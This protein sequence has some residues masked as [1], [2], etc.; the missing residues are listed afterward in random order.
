[1]CQVYA[2]V[3]H[4]CLFLYLLLIECETPKFPRCLKNVTVR[5]TLFYVLSIVHC[6]ATYGALCLRCLS[7][8]WQVTL[9]VDK[10]DSVTV[11]KVPHYLRR[12]T[13]KRSGLVDYRL[14][15][16]RRQWRRRCIVE[17]F[18]QQYLTANQRGDLEGCWCS[19]LSVRRNAPG[20]PRADRW[21]ALSTC[22]R[23][24]RAFDG[25]HHAS[26]AVQNIRIRGYGGRREIRRAAAGDFRPTVGRP[27]RPQL[28]ISFVRETAWRRRL[29][30]IAGTM[31]GYSP[32]DPALC[33]STTHGAALICSSAVP[34]VG[35]GSV[36]SPWDH[37]H[38]RRT[39][40][41]LHR[42]FPARESLLAG[43]CNIRYGERTGT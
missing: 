34:P 25:R 15:N 20:Q 40:S 6:R 22:E 33:D 23:F 27:R 32:V 17:Q 21:P 42:I 10:G 28:M 41:R 29:E 37:T 16:E 18:Q 12:G 2:Y 14:D 5:I 30:L 24:C 4:L 8:P 7:T 13:K 39:A 19:L 35:F 1:V 3:R 9:K 38:T 36:K 43:V 11:S 26:N 31:C